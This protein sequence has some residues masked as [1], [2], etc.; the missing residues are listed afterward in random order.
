[1]NPGEVA[2]LLAACAMYDFRT[3]EKPDVAAWAHVIGDLDYDDA[4][5]AVRRHYQAQT[6]RMMPAHVRQGVKTI[7]EERR[8]AEKS[9]ARELPSVFEEDMNRQVRMEKGAAQVR[10]VL[11]ELTAHLDRKSPAPVSAMEQLRAIT[12][13]PAWDASESEASR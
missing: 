10:E 1:M 2:R 3:V 4:M 9:A 5:E 7:R 8:R 12:A 11:A 13:G 6:D